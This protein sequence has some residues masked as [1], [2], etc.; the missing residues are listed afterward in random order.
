MSI[1]KHLARAPAIRLR[2]VAKQFDRALGISREHI[3][4][5]IGHVFE[6]PSSEI[7]IFR[8]SD[9]KY[10][11]TLTTNK[12]RASLVVVENVIAYQ[13]PTL[14][15]TKLSVHTLADGKLH[16]RVSCEMPIPISYLFYCP[17]INGIMYTSYSISAINLDKLTMSRIAC[18]GTIRPATAVFANTQMTIYKHAQEM[19]IVLPNDKRNSIRSAPFAGHARY[20]A[21]DINPIHAQYVAGRAS[22]PDKITIFDIAQSSKPMRHIPCRY[23]HAASFL[24]PNLLL[25]TAIQP[26]IFDMRTALLVHTVHVTTHIDHSVVSVFDGVRSNCTIQDDDRRVWILD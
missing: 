13:E 10:I 17:M 5:R 14:T 12:P 9:L 7:H 23:S 19:S 6:R 11:T 15:S 18:S 2:P 26:F 22:D 8:L 4:L 21:L 3:Y 20:T 24:D 16:Q 25:V 1:D